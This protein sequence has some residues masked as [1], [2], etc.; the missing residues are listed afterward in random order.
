MLLGLIGSFDMMESGGKEVATAAILY[1]LK[2]FLLASVTGL[3]IAAVPVVMLIRRS[4]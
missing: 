2:T 1:A 3:L 4:H